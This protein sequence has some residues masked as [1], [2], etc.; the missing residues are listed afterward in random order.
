MLS[1]A[2]LCIDYGKCY[3]LL[4]FDSFVQVTSQYI[5][6]PLIFPVVFPNVFLILFAK[7]NSTPLSFPLPF[8]F[9]QLK[10]QSTLAPGCHFGC[11][12]LTKKMAL[13]NVTSQ[14]IILQFLALCISKIFSFNLISRRFISLYNLRLVNFTI[15][16]IKQHVTIYYNFYKC[17][18]RLI[19]PIQKPM[20]NY[21]Y[22]K[23]QPK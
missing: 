3:L 6:K 12:N 1:N 5:F 4:V 15:F 18:S 22:L 10:W 14:F 19:D 9:F 17:C 11:Q 7:S 2:K 21:Q 16:I 8:S 23:Q 20:I 13:P